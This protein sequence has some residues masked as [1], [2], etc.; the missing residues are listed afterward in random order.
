MS[1][2]ESLE[3]ETNVSYTAN[4]AISNASTL[5]PVL[6]FFSKAAAMRG[7]A[8]QAVGLFE[9]AYAA[10][11]E[12]AVRALF[13]LRDVRGGQGERDLFRE[14]FASLDPKV[15]AQVVEH[16]PEYGRWDDID[17]VANFPLVKAQLDED[18]KNATEGKSV[19]LLAKWL[20]SENASSKTSRK[21]AR[22]LAKLLKVTPR[23]YRK[24]VAALRAR[25]KLLEQDMSTKNWSEIDYAKLPSQALRKHI[26]AFKRNDNTR[27]E[28]YLEDVASGK[29]KINASTLF[30][31]EVY[32]LIH[33]GRDND[34]TA[35]ALWNNLPDYTNGQN[36]L[37][38]ADVS[39]SMT[40]AYGSSVSPMSV[41]VSLA[42][43]FADKNKGLFHDYFMT[44]SDDSKLQKV[45]GNTLREKMNSIERAEW[46]MSTNL[47]SAFDAILSAA[48]DANASQE[49]MP[50]T[51]YIIS[52]MQFNE[53]TYR[54]RDT[55]LSVA[56]KKFEE[57]GY[58]LPQVVFWNVNAYADAPATKYD[59]GVTLISGS[60]QSTFK[61][62]FEGKTPL[63][64]ML[65]VL[66]SDRY[67]KIKL[68]NSYEL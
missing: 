44:F 4:G 5:D 31:Y 37:V 65:E 63:E 32:N 62:V 15:R 18:V 16:V 22:E 3:K 2:I 40:G 14:I 42:L 12:L 47:Q 11:N 7:R 56:H 46:G 61:F 64:S 19:S 58:K 43:Y 28:Q 68:V 29:Q 24:K 59:E 52:D 66:N 30:A 25:I 9:K 55:N 36:A 27:Y 10:N 60:S 20:P 33:N 48:L 6:D 57:A 54:N 67:A 21:T 26:A 8:K 45:R 13:W 35:D 49:E 39:G 38:V 23:Q 1:F 50:A 34:T 53:A 17:F 41:S 51:L